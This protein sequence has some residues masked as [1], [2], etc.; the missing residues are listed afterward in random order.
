MG[1]GDTSSLGRAEGVFVYV[2]M[3]AHGLKLGR[4]D[5]G[6]QVSRQLDSVRFVSASCVC[7]CVCKR[8]ECHGHQILNCRPCAL[9]K[10]AQAVG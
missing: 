1:F 2:C 8:V 6:T 3:W 9:V 7:M 5:L 10:A 4:P